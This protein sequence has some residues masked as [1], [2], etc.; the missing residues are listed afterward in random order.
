[1]AQRKGE[2][3]AAQNESECPYIIELKM[4]PNGLGAKLDLIHEFHRQ[5]GLDIRRGRGERRNDQDYVRWCFANREDAEAFE[6][7]FR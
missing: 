3:T 6:K 7:A 5:R 2:R 4:P 1:M